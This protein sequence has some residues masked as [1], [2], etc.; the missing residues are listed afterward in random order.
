MP[1]A[2][3]KVSS[4][5][6]AANRRVGR[7]IGKLEAEGKPRRQAIAQAINMVGT[8]EQKARGKRMRKK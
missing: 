7:K 5:K 3:R 6:R 8:P 4:N 2:P 1:K